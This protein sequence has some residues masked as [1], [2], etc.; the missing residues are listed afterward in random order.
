LNR[1]HRVRATITVMSRRPAVVVAG[2]VLLC[3]LA[4]CSNDRDRFRDRTLPKPTARAGIPER[5]PGT[6]DKTFTFDGARR[7]YRVYVP[8]SLPAGKAV[9]AVLVLHGGFG[10]GKGAERQGNWDSAANRGRFLLVLPDGLARS[11]N[12]GSCCGPPQRNGVDDV[13]FLTELLE[14]VTSDYGVDPTRVY[15]T[16]ISNGGMMAYRF[17][18]V[19]A[20]RLA[21]IAPVAADLIVDCRPARPVSLLHFHGLADQNVPI[22][23]GVPTKSFQANRP[24]YPPVRDGVELLAR[25]DGCGVTPATTTNGP[26]TTV[27]WTGCTDQ[28][29]VELVTI[30]GGGH[31]WPG[32]QRLAQILD[33]PSTAIDATAAIWKFFEEHPRR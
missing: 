27:R 10:T 29:A 26:L 25:A 6:F 1:E 30:E 8:S 23:G 22:G 16:G 9:P 33:P 13:S 4:S 18:C 12:A 32:G 7:T 24:T 21:A 2:A 20:D 31:S 15:A 11:W 5:T 28:A 3:T 14:R 17:A 19:A